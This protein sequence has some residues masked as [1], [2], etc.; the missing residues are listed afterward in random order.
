MHNHQQ[1]NNSPCPSPPAW[2]I[3]QKD[4]N[5]MVRW[6]VSQEI[7]LISQQRCWIDRREGIITLPCS[8]CWRRAAIFWRIAMMRLPNNFLSSLCPSSIA[9]SR[10]AVFLVI[11]AFRS[12]ISSSKFAMSKTRQD[13]TGD[14]KLK[15]CFCV[16]LFC[17]TGHRSGNSQWNVSISTFLPIPKW[18]CGIQK[19]HP[20]ASFSFF[21]SVWSLVVFFTPYWVFIEKLK[22]ISC[23]GQKLLAFVPFF[24]SMRDRH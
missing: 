22:K 23:S 4:A 7:G 9:L 6:G 21:N 1:H 10:R 17:V 8:C 2:A 19:P 16:V 20:L 24:H 14:E 3:L 18:D 13:E 5:E 12:R 15:L 11:S